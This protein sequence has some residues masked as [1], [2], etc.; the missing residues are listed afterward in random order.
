MTFGEFSSQGIV[1]QYDEHRWLATFHTTGM[2]HSPKSAMG[3]SWETTPWH[4]V[5]RA[6]WEALKRATD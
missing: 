5:Q 6:T 4:A 2:E 1:L 3:A